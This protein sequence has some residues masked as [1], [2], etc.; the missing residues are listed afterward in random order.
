MKNPQPSNLEMQILSVLWENGPCTVRDI[1]DKIPDGK[2]R[3]YTTVLTM[4]QIM[5]KKKLV[6][7]KSVGNTPCIPANKSQESHH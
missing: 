6:T 7:H 1:L 5:E 4:M 3:A 2:K